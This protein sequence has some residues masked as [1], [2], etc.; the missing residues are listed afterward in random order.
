MKPEGQK[1]K[2]FLCWGIMVYFYMN[3]FLFAQEVKKYE[4]AGSFYPQKREVLKRQIHFYLEEAEVPDIKGKIVGIICPHAG[5]VYSGKVAGYSFAAIKDKHFDTVIIMGPS[6]RYY[7]RGISIYKKGFF[8]TSLGK[9]EVDEEVAKKIMQG[10]E[11]VR[12]TPQH[13]SGEH[14]IEVELPFLIEVLKNFKIVPLIFGSLTYEELKVF[15]KRLVEVCKD[16]NILIVVSTDLSHYHPYKVANKIDAQTIREIKEKD[17][18][19]LWN[20]YKSQE[21]RACGILPLI[22]FLLY[23]KERN[24][25]IKILKYANSGDTSGNKSKVVGY[26]SAIGYISDF[27]KLSFTTKVNDKSKKGGEEMLDYSLTTEDKITLLKIARKSLES[28]LSKGKIPHFEVERQTLKEKRGV[29]VT[30]KKQDELRGCIGRIVAD[31]PLYE[32]VAKVAV[33]SA[34]G[35]PRFPPL[36]LEELKD[37]EIEISVLTPFKKV[38]DLE[39]IV[40]GRDGLMI[41]KGFHS[42][43]LLPQV[44]VEYGWDRETFLEHLCYKAGLPP[45][46]YKEKDAVI[47]KFSALVFSES[48]LLTP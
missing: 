2:L 13:F 31:T 45:Y 25:E 15:S 9:V 39:K 10:I 8:H 48:Q 41:Q 23:I 38:E 35:D 26:V 18:H 14:C 34:V 12:F 11:W 21:L 24:G 20:S 7:F 42:G 27:H 29:F 32:G 47:Y 19:T 17:V 28:Y 36:K 37:I 30:L 4:F 6:H 33:D 40:V 22:S 44:P 1:K 5:Y 46:A 3:G 16:R 43:L